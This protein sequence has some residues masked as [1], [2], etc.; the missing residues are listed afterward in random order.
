MSYEARIESCNKIWRMFNLF[1]YL[2]ILVGMDL[3]LKWYGLTLIGVV[4]ALVGLILIKGIDDDMR[5]FYKKHPKNPG[6]IV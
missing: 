6:G 1:R 5:K 4:I 3:V 2:C